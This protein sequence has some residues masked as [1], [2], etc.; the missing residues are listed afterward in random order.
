[1]PIISVYNNK[2]GEGKSTVTIGLAEFLAARKDQKVLVIDLDAQASSSC[3]LLGQ[4]TLRDAV[5]DGQTV[6]SLIDE[7]HRK[8]RPVKKL[9][10]FMIWRPATDANRACETLKERFGKSYDHAR[11]VTRE[12][13]K[14]CA[15]FDIA[16]TKPPRRSIWERLGLA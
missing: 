15:S 11:K 14:R 1:M 16:E 2:G 12:L 10:R 6:S 7:I 5:P 8:R 3:A 9:D 4:E 13:E